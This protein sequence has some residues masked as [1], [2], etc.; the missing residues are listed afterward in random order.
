MF[1]LVFFQVSRKTTMAAILHI[2]LTYCFS[3]PIIKLSGCVCAAKLPLKL[4]KTHKVFLHNVSPP[5][6]VRTLFIEEKVVKV[7]AFPQKW[8]HTFP[9]YEV[10]LEFPASTAC[11]QTHHQLMCI[12]KHDW[13]STK[14]LF[15]DPFLPTTN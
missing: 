4:I 14:V 2:V 9:T 13:I 11:T 15:N 3:K 7:L 1:L 6:L 5:H 12:L 10:G 8:G